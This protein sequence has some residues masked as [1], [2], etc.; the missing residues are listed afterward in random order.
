MWCSAITF[1]WTFVCR[2]SWSFSTPSPT[3]TILMPYGIVPGSLSLIDSGVC[4]HVGGPSCP[5]AWTLVLSGHPPHTSPPP[6]IQLHRDPRGEA[7]KGRVTLLPVCILP[8]FCFPSQR[9]DPGDALFI[10]AA[11]IPNCTY[12][13][14]WLFRDTNTSWSLSHLWISRTQLRGAPALS[15][16]MPGPSTGCPL[17]ECL[18]SGACVT[19]GKL[20]H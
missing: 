13:S 17:P 6:I 3:R 16:E 4:I 5:V 15:V 11:V 2:L 19:S 1:C 12:R 9:Q 18:S 10:Q 20:L 7:Q 8:A 14:S